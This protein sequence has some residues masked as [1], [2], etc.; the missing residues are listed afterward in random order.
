VGQR[1]G[2]RGTGFAQA[3]AHNPGVYTARIILRPGVDVFK[4]VVGIKPL[5]NGVIG[6]NFQQNVQCSEGIRGAN[7][8]DQQRCPEFLTGVVRVD[9]DRGDIGER[10]TVEQ[11]GGPNDRVLVGDD[12]VETIRLFSGRGAV[13]GFEDRLGPGIWAKDQRIKLRYVW[14]VGCGPSPLC[15]AGRQRKRFGWDHVR[16]F[17]GIL[18]SWPRRYWASTGCR[19]RPRRRASSP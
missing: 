8:P 17:L 16:R 11:T 14:D 12:L 9:P 13:L 7:Q 3:F 15:I 10:W 6:P 4:S 2:G 19:P 1:R 18:A 5:G